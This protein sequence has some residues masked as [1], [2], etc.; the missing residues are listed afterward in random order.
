MDHSTYNKMVA[1]IRQRQDGPITIRELAKELKITQKEIY[2][3]CESADLTLNVATGIKGFG[4]AL[5][6]K[7]NCTVEDL[8]FDIHKNAANETRSDSK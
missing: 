3:E 8:S 1:L 7:G 5:L 2:E 6:A 4:Y